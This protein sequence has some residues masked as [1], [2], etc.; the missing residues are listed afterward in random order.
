MLSEKC[1]LT[2]SISYITF[3]VLFKVSNGMSQN[4]KYRFLYEF[5]SQHNRNVIF[6]HLSVY[7]LAIFFSRTNLI[8]EPDLTQ[9]SFDLL[10]L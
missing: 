9:R 8:A 3:L 10:K 1:F 7:L 2:L 5:C 6:G 4:L